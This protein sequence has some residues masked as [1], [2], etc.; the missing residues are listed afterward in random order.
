[1]NK[2]IKKKKNHHFNVIDVLVIVVAAAVAL[3]LAYFFI[4]GQN[5]GGRGKKTTLRYIIMLEKQ[6][7]MLH[8]FI[9]KSDMV[10]DNDSG[11]ILGTVQNVNYSDTEYPVYDE[12]N[13]IIR[14]STYENYENAYVEVTSECSFTEDR[15]TVSGISIAAGRQVSFRTPSYIGKGTIISVEEIKEPAVL[16]NP[17]AAPQQQ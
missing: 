2:E 17:E 1:M 10:I 3:T 7:K 14:I 15:Y 16:S 9:N 8:G 13:D 5:I 12:A 6:D 4:S 11:N